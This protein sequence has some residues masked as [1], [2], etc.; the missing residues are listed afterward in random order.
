MGSS[1]PCMHAEKVSSHPLFNPASF[2]LIP[3]CNFA[4]RTAGGIERTSAAAAVADSDR[5]KKA[6]RLGFR[7]NAPA[8]P[9]A[10]AAKAACT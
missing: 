1:N 9:A 7:C 4:A 3:I 8:A 2:S 10:K 6:R 5:R